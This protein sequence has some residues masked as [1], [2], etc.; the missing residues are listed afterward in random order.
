[1]LTKISSSPPDRWYMQ[2]A[3]PSG[4]MTA[5]SEFVIT[6]QMPAGIRGAGTAFHPPVFSIKIFHFTTKFAKAV[7]VIVEGCVCLVSW[8]D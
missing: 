3:R 5:G 8:F 2:A 4:G 7:F 6:M 1:M